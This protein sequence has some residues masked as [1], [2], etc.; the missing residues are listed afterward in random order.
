MHSL[1]HMLYFFVW[2]DIISNYAHPVS[3]QKPRVLNFSIENVQCMH[4][5]ALK[6]NARLWD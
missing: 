3:S 2:V 5:Q 1:V 6:H 4:T